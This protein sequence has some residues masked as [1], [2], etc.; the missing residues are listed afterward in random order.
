M[1]APPPLQLTFLFLSLL[2]LLLPPLLASTPPSSNPSAPSFPHSFS[3]TVHITSNLLP[4]GIEYPPKLRSYRI[5]YS[6]PLQK[7]KIEV[8]EGTDKGTTYLRSYADKT[9]YEV[10]TGDYPSCSRSHLPTDMPAPLLPAL[11]HIGGSVISS[12]DTNHFVHATSLER[13]H[14]YF[15]GDVPVRLLHEDVSQGG[16]VATAL[17]T[18]D[19]EDVALVGEGGFE[20]GVWELG[21]DWTREKCELHVGGF[22]YVHLWHWYLRV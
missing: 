16:D 18:Y 6:V 4:D 19:Y 8:L 15:A 17:M 10:R 5:H 1:P 13:T 3:A 11:I 2:S 14:M 9:E 7:A 20:E 21:G 12:A 22:P